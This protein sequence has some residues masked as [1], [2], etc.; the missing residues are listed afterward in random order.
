MA[1]DPAAK[2]ALLKDPVERQRLKVLAEAENPIGHLIEWTSYFI[3]ETFSE[4]TAR[5]QGRFLQE[6]SREEGKE[7]FDLLMDIVCADG[8][9][10]KLCPRV[11]EH[12]AE[13]WVVNSELI[14]DPRVVI[15]AS[16]AGAHVD[17]QGGFNYPTE[18]L[19][20]LVREQG[21]F[22]VEE[23]VSQLSSVPA[24][25]V[26]LKD[27]GVIAEG[28][29]ADLVVFDDDLVGSRPLETRFD[30]PGGAGRLYADSIGVDHVFVAGV[31]IVVDG[32]LTDARPGAVL[33]SGRDT[34]DPSM[35]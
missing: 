29:H 30:L 22:S 3:V 24:Q 25:L 27:R 18:L 31:E 15:G 23:L 26:G 20:Y 8:L 7:P 19:H 34:A 13:D 32:K 6:A 17:M 11:L 10:T 5:F 9:R 4:E 16:D 14:R 2:L 33:R 12:D 21:L 1:L 28:A 35:V